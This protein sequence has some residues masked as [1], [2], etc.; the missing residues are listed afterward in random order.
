MVSAAQARILIAAGA[1]VLDA[2]DRLAQWWKPLP[3]AVSVAWDDFS[4]SSERAGLGLLADDATL[5]EAFRALGVSAARPVVVVGDALSGW[6]EDGRIVWTLRSRGHERAV[7][8]DGGYGALAAG[9]PFPITAPVATG[10]WT[11]R[12]DP[13]LEATA[14]EVRDA[15]ARPDV[16]VI[17]TREPREFAGATPYGEAR[18][19][20]VPGARHLHFKD[21]LGADGRLL[22][23]EALRG[24]LAALGVTPDKEVIAYC[25]GGVRSGYFT[26]VLQTLGIR[27]Q[28]YAGSMWEWSAGP[29]Q[30]YPLVK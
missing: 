29:V 30:S 9:G 21:V 3:G 10:D 1:L 14:D 19:G 20:H 12:T 16:V 2:R 28:N 23:P 13:S 17:D 6:G 5:T 8:V 22:A 7:L 11:A 18:G 27:A 25:T 26:S 15:L 4:R 24:K